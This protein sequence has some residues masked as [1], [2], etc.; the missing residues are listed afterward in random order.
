MFDE[1]TSGLSSA[2]SEKVIILLK[3]QAL[4]GKLVITNIHQPSSDVFK[5]LD[6]LN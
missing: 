2:D 4:K 6:K 3:R 5:M 1:P